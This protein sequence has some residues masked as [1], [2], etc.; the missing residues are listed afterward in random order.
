MIYDQ[1]RYITRSYIPWH[2][3]ILPGH[4]DILPGHE[5]IL[6][7]HDILPIGSIY[8]TGWV[9]IYQCI[10]KIE[11]KIDKNLSITGIS[12]SITY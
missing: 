1:A 10:L 6:P 12:N 8:I 11:N 4:E 5:D 9:N 2:E 7:G 3:D